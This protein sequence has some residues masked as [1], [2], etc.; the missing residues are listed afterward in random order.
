MLLKI[1]HVIL[2]VTSL[3]PGF[4]NRCPK[5]VFSLLSFRLFGHISKHLI[6][7]ESLFF[8]LKKNVIPKSSKL[9]H[10]LSEPLCNFRV[11]CFLFAILSNSG[12]YEKQ[13]TSFELVKMVS[14]SLQLAPTGNA[15]SEPNHEFSGAMALLVSGRVVFFKAKTH[16][17]WFLMRLHWPCLF[18]EPSMS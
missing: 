7:V 9:G 4:G 6:P 10:W 3:Q 2:V 13:C 18:L 11:C 14:T 1:I 17:C 15:P 12:K 16:F 5:Y 8:R